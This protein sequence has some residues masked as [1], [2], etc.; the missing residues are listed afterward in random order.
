M[1]RLY[2]FI[3][4]ENLT[5]DDYIIH[6]SGYPVANERFETLTAEDTAVLIPI[7][8][9]LMTGILY[10]SFRSLAATIVP[11]LI[12]A[13]GVLLILEIQAYLSIPHTSI[14]SA[15]LAPT[16]IIIGIGITVHVL[17]EFFNFRISSA[18]SIE[19]AHATITHL[20]QPAFYTA[21]TTSAGFLALSVTKIAPMR[22]FAILG[23]MGPLFLFLFSL[24][25]LPAMLSYIGKLSDKTRDVMESGFVSRI[26]RK[27]PDF[28]LRNRNTILFIGFASLVS[29]SSICPI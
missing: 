14:D 2:R 21:L 22:E 10:A 3:E 24:S 23:A 5:S 26:T 15:A 12:I 18:N 6:L 25:V 16:L 1:Q 9:V 7:M 8:I 19:A 28:T 29:Q 4:D 17:I 13:T 27:V 20:W 11:W